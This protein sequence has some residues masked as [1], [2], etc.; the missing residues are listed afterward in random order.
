MRD[1]T[2]PIRI[3]QIL[4]RNPC[5]SLHFKKQKQKQKQK[6]KPKQKQKQKQKQILIA[7]NN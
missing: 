3:L 2:N 6:Q 5:D 7:I 1:T 4:M